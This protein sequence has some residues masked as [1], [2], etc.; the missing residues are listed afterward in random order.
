M[1]GEFGL[2]NSTCLL[3]SHFNDPQKQLRRPV[4]LGQ[5][6]DGAYYWC[7]CFDKFLS[8]FLWSCLTR[9]SFDFHVVF[10]PKSGE[11]NPQNL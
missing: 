3:E 4:G 9:G 7:I 2:A 10:L 1:L 11:F 8:S 5:D 6:A